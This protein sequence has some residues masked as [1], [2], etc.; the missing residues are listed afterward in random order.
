MARNAKQAR[1]AFGVVDGATGVPAPAAKP[2]T[3]AETVDVTAYGLTPR[4][5]LRTDAGNPDPAAEAAKAA[6]QRGDWRAVSAAM[7]PLQMDPNRYQQVCV[8]AAGVAENDEAWLFA[9]LDAAPSDADAWNVHAASLVTLA[10]KLR[11][12]AA[13]KDVLPGQWIGF[14]RVLEQAPAACERAAELAPHLATPWISLM[15]CAQ[16]LSYDH[17]RFREIYAEGYRRAPS[18][19]SVHRRGL[20]YWLPRWRGSDELAA[21][22]VEKSL[23]R[24]VP[25]QLLTQLRLEYL[26]FERLPKGTSERAAFFKGPEAAAALQ[27]SLADLAAARQDNPYLGAQQHWLAYFLTK[28]GRYP[29]AAAMFQAVDGYAGAW[30]WQLFNDPAATFAA[31]RAE[32]LIGWERAAGRR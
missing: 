27:E 2:A 15:S 21:Q 18:S 4:A 12:S 24:A 19:L 25:G 16:G 32:A 6:A 30:P 9:W 20:Q 7:Q 31:V 1:P 23:A 5:Q 17:A 22:F 13:A 29:E 28:A 14:K 3:P 10:W 8:A 11:T 26:Y